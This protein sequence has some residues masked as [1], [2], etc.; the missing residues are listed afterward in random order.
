AHATGAVLGTKS[1][2]NSTCR[3]DGNPE[4]LLERLPKSLVQ[5]THPQV[6]SPPTSLWFP[7]HNIM[8]N[9]DLLLSYYP[10]LRSVKFDWGEKEEAAFQLLKQK[11][12][13]ALILALPK[14][15]VEHEKTSWLELLND[16]DCEIHY[17]P[18]KAN[19]VADALSQKERIKP[20]QHVIPVWKWENITMDFVSK[21]P[22][23]STGQDTI[24]VIVD[25]FTKSAHFLPMKENDS[26]E[27]LT[28]LYL[29]EVVTRHDVPFFIISD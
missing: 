26:M 28:R 10:H 17:H 16:Y 4:S 2:S 6:A 11:L 1:N 5:S 12:C 23:T 22:K 14:E 18:R 8:F 21:L 7:L 25:R 9:V 15:G 13:C 27:K 24:W 29:K 3:V 19:V 20:L